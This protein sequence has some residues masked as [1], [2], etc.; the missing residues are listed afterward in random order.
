MK[1]Q[2]VKTGIIM[3]FNGNVNGD[4]WKAIEEPS[5]VSDKAEDKP[6]KVK[7]VKK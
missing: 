4:N 1:Y 5:S 7:K 3:S 6:V 2:N